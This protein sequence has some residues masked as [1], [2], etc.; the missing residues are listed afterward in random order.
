MHQMVQAAP[1]EAASRIA[2][3]NFL[4]ALQRF[5]EAKEQMSMLKQLDSLQD[6]SAEIKLLE[7]TLS[8]QGK[9]EP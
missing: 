5:D 2:L 7:Q 8:G 1:Q 6:H 9:N 4:V 3:I